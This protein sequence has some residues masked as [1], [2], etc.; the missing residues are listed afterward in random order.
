MKFKY[1]GKLIR[2]FNKGEIKGFTDDQLLVI[3]PAVKDI[4]E[5]LEALGPMFYLAT[6]E[7]QS[8]HHILDMFAVNRDIK[9]D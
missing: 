7:I 8:L 2:Q 5:F 6:S 1:A 9:K 4:L 3:I